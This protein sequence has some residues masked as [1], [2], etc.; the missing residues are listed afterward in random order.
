MNRNFSKGSTS[1]EGRRG[2]R[3]TNEPRGNSYQKKDGNK[4]GNKSGNWKGRPYQKKK[5]KY[6]TESVSDDGTIRL[7]RYIAQS[8]ICSRREADVLIQTGCVEVNGV[9]TT[10]LG[11]RILPADKVSVSGE[12]IKNE[13]KVYVLL[14]KPKDFIT[15]SKDPQNRR[16]VYELIKD[17][18]KERVYAVGRLDRMTTGLLL[19]TND[20]ALADRLMHP[21]NNIQKLYH[22][23][24]DKP[25]KQSELEEIRNGIVLED[26]FI[27]AD[28]IEYSDLENKK[29]VGIKIHSGR[30]R[31]VRRIFEHFGYRVLK[32]DRVMYAGLTKYNLPRGKW[33]ILEGK[34][35]E[36]LKRTV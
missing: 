12:T 17:A 29:E 28:D 26:G 34:D 30:N 4:D 20:G 21:S 15:T 32:L 6:N 19:F 1:R 9:V 5:K 36:I 27:K 11:T 10:G 2:D 35:L 13:K 25:L 8:G 16:T 14:N 7:N 31:I 24:L 22:V 18:C 33:R 3:K 23:H